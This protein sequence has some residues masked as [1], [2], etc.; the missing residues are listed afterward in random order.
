MGRC[1][2]RASYALG[3]CLVCVGVG[4]YVSACVH[5]G[6]KCGEKGFGRW[7]DRCNAT[8]HFCAVFMFVSSS[9]RQCRLHARTHA[10]LCAIGP[11][12][13]D[14]LNRCRLYR[15]FIALTLFVY[16]LAY[17]HLQSRTHCEARL[18]MCAL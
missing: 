10:G 5:V 14:L 3:V 13:R 15:G 17:L 1:T 11:H 18:I 6:V 8:L 16:L 2:G 12:D 7:R 9:M 4:V